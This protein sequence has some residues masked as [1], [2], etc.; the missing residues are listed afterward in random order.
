MA[1]IIA[2]IGHANAGKTTL[3]RHLT[4]A[5]QRNTTSRLKDT[6]GK[7]LVVY[8]YRTLATQEGPSR[9]TPSE[10]ILQ[11]KALKLNADIIV[12]PMRIEGILNTPGFEGYLSELRK[13]GYIVKSNIIIR[14][15][16][17]KYV[18][19]IPDF[20]IEYIDWDSSNIVA[21]KARDFLR[22]M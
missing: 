14:D 1:K 22:L 11:L 21:K 13:N 12:I 2:I 18:C 15:K 3:I 10:M 9:V 17:N 5:G 8:I 7:I 6:S 20:Q 16:S 19:E 4:G